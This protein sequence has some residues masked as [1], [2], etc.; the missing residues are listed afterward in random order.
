MPSNAAPTLD[1][2]LTKQLFLDEIGADEIVS[3]DPRTTPRRRGTVLGRTGNRL[4]V[5]W[6]DS[7]RKVWIDAKHVR[8]WKGRTDAIPRRGYV[9]QANEGCILA[10]ENPR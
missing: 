2:I 3:C 7:G 8:Y 9:V 10:A 5:E 1:T 6:F 4:W